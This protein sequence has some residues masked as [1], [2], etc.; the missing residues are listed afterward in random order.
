MIRQ[1]RLFC[2]SH[3]AARWETTTKDFDYRQE[4][5]QPRLIW[6]GLTRDGNTDHSRRGS[7]AQSEELLMPVVSRQPDKEPVRTRPDSRR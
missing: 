7:A 6:Q 4:D 5:V 1:N 2:D 3:D